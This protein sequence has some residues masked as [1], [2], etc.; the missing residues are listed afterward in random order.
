MRAKEAHIET[1]QKT[2]EQVVEMAEK[3]EA[4]IVS[5]IVPKR[6]GRKTKLAVQEQSYE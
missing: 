2:I 3:T 5:D 6:R 1:P 4:P